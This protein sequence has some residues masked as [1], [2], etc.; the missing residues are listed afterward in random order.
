MKAEIL[1]ENLANDD[2]IFLLP[3]RDVEF[4]GT[5][6]KVYFSQMKNYKEKRVVIRREFLQLMRI[7]Y[8]G[9]YGIL[10]FG[11]KVRVA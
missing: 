1:Y 3:K 10:T 4:F 5:G 6:G 7:E 11:A 8:S 9:E 2:G